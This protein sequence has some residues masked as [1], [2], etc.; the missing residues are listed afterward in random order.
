MELVEWIRDV[1][2][3]LRYDL[4][5]RKLAS[6][7][8]E[9]WR[10]GIIPSPKEVAALRKML[11]KRATCSRLE[12]DGSCRWL[13]KNASSQGLRPPKAGER[14]VCRRQEKGPVATLYE[15]CEGFRQAKEDK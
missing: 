5:V 6:K 8:A 3:D 10:A 9:K 1:A 15:S 14:A 4:D 13:R 2:T 11:P 7:L 12:R